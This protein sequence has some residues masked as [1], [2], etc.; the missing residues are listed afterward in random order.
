MFGGSRAHDL[1]LTARAIDAVEAERIGLV[2][3]VVPD[4]EA[5]PAALELADTLCEYSPFGVTITKEVLWANV[6][7]PSVEAAISLENRNQILAT[8]TGDV[9]RAVTAFAERSKSG[10]ENRET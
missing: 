8:T 1:I 6:D 9:A 7:A 4:G 3:R 2:S 10:A 5:L